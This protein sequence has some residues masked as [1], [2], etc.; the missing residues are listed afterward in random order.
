[1]GSHPSVKQYLL[2]S[3]PGETLVRRSEPLPADAAVG[4]LGERPAAQAVIRPA[5][6]EPY[7]IVVLARDQV[8]RGARDGGDERHSPA[9]DLGVVGSDRRPVLLGRLPRLASVTRRSDQYVLDHAS[10]EHPAEVPLTRLLFRHV[11]VPVEEPALD[12]PQLPTS[13]PNSISLLAW[14]GNG[15]S[16]CSASSIA[17]ALTDPL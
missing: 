8:H 7:L 13:R 16:A 2:F 3:D 15:P 5:A 10:L 9:V 1:M 17:E 6:F 14:S 12:V 11:P 4:H